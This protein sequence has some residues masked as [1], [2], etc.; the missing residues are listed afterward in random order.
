MK[1]TTKASLLRRKLVKKA[2][3]R[4]VRRKCMAMGPPFFFVKRSMFHG[5]RACVVGL[6]V[7]GLP[8]LFGCC[9]YPLDVQ[10]SRRGEGGRKGQYIDS[11]DTCSKRG[12]PNCWFQASTGFIYGVSWCAVAVTKTCPSQLYDFVL[13]AEIALGN[14]RRIACCIGWYRPPVCRIVLLTTLTVKDMLFF[15]QFL[16]L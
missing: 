12:V 10:A 14:G 2:E 11:R 4:S 1:F 3:R 9:L 13:G 5:Q 6:L 8:D 15:S 7:L 16:T